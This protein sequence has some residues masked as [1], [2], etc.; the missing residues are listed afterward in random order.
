MNES[1]LKFHTFPYT[2]LNFFMFLILAGLALHIELELLAIIL[3][4]IPAGTQ[5]RGL[6]TQNNY[7]KEK[8][9]TG[10]FGR[11]YQHRAHKL[12]SWTTIE[13][14]VYEISFMT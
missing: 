8:K 4:T 2:P 9:I 10:A 1:V 12:F 3:A 5:R 13:W 11:V 6:P 7:R 14:I